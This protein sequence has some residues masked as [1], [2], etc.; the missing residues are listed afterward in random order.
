MKLPPAIGGL[1]PFA[2][3]ARPASTRAQRVKLVCLLV[4]AAEVAP[5]TAIAAENGSHDWLQYSI[6]ILLLIQTVLV[7]ALLIQDRRRR[8]AQRNADRLQSEMTHAAR[9]ALAGEITASIAHEITQ[10][11]SAIL[12]NVETAELL[13]SQPIANTATLSDI[14]ADIKRDDLRAHEIVRRLR[15]L[16][17]K[18][19]MRQERH[20]LNALVSNS[21]ALLRADAIRRN[22][23]V[24]FDLEQGLPQ[25]YVDPVHLQQ[26]VLNLLLNAM[27]AMVETPTGERTLG[28]QTRLMPQ[29]AIEIAVY[30]SGHGMT[31]EQ[32]TR[33][34]DSF[35]TTKEGGMG[36]GLSIA[37]SIVHAHGGT[38]WAENRDGG[39]TIFR[40]RIPLHQEQESQHRQNPLHAYSLK[41][42]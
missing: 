36:L 34:F 27:D 6:G 11:L 30:D 13:L 15:S 4:L 10:P 31:R 38:I 2:S 29:S 1:L 26:V 23:L 18:R 35:F 41:L 9:L 42:T 33:A 3:R 37:R 19:E 40:V 39:G 12:S 32:L 5:A 20:D 17:R 25:V 21:V 8:R 16:L 7:V 22:V 24:T 14:L 28:V